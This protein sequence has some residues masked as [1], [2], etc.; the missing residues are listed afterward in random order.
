[1]ADDHSAGERH[2]SW[3]ELFFDLV[4]VAGIAQLAHVLSHGPSLAD[5][6]LYVLLYLAFW[7]TWATFTVY[8]R[9]RGEKTRILPILL[10]MMGLAVMVASV[11]GV[12]EEHTTA[13]VVALYRSTLARRSH[14][15]ADA[16]RR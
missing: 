10:A 12:R 16:D 13:F 9:V 7:I 3:I 14:L 6:G 4:L 8:G 15:R 11:P 5:L 1:M 2:A